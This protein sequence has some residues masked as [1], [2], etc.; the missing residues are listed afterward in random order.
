MHLWT[1]YE[2]NVLAGYPIDRLQRSEGRSAFFTTATPDGKPALL[3]LTESHFDES[4]L[5]GR[6]HKIAAVVH[7]HLQAIQHSGQITYDGVP[8]ACCL[9][10]PIDASLADVLRD[11]PLTLDETKEVA[12]AV[13]GALAA[14]HAADLIHEHLDA[15]NVYAH[16]ETVKL[17]SDCVRECVGDFEADTPEAR[18]ALRKRDVHDLGLLLLRCL[19]ME[20][21]G[22]SSAKLPRPLDRIIPGALDGTLTAQAVMDILKPTPLAVATKPAAASEL[23]ALAQQSA[24]SPAAVLDA[25]ATRDASPKAATTVVSASTPEPPRTTPISTKPNDPFDVGLGSLRN[26]PRY[27]AGT[28]AMATGVLQRL[29]PL[30]ARPVS[31]KA[32]AI[33]GGLAALLAIVLWITLGS[34]KPTSGTTQAAATPAPAQTVVDSPARGPA[35]KPADT[36]FLSSTAQAGWHVI[37]YTYNHEQQAQAKVSKLQQRYTNLQPQV[38]SPTGHAPYFVALGGPLD[39]SSAYALRNRARQS[40]LPR[41]TYA[42]NF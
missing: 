17:R 13:A 39:S 6:W 5:I 22:P 12:E 29:R 7:P 27:Q 23:S 9:L 1:E 18:E 38:F 26:E 21:Q 42:R 36:S 3:R 35:T 37:A 4:E 41:D 34:S 16:D 31:A 19:A 30:K 2:G 24:N 33:I 8:L 11:R 20:W 32:Y 25:L 14:L 15:T 40:G 28:E 10:E